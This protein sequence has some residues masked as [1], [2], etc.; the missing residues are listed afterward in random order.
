MVAKKLKKLMNQEEENSN[1]WFLVVDFTGVNV[2]I[3][4]NSSKFI[5]ETDDIF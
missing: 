4:N 2:G 5:Y 1:S 3:V